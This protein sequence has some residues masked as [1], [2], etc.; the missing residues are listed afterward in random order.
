M[1]TKKIIDKNGLVIPGMLRDNNG[2]IIIDNSVAEEEYNNKKKLFDRVSKLEDN[3]ID[4]NKK[5]DLIVS[6]ILSTH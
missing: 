2:A 3:L 4:L 5:M 6:K 1:Y